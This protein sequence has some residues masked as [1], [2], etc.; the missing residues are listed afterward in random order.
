LIEREMVEVSRLMSTFSEKVC[1]CACVCVCVCVCASLSSRHDAH[2]AW[3]TQ[4]STQ[5]VLGA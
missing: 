1:A 4:P 3:V 5:A 2:A